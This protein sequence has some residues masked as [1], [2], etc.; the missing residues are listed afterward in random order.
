MINF[1]IAVVLVLTAYG[2]IFCIICGGLF[3][4]TRRNEINIKSVNKV[5]DNHRLRTDRIV[6]RIDLIIQMIGDKFDEVNKKIEAEIKVGDEVIYIGESQRRFVVT[7]VCVQ[8]GNTLISGFDM[9]GSQYCDKSVSNWKKTGRH[10]DQIEEL[11]G[12][13]EED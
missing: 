2:I 1:E 12:K 10:F 8:G 7:Q 3:S 6:N 5:L 9:Y 11:L 13:M 4:R